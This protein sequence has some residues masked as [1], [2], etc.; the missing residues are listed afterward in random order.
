[1]DRHGHYALFDCILGFIV[2]VVFL[3]TLEAPEMNNF[4]S[5]A[6]AQKTHDL[7]A[8]WQAEKIVSP[9]ELRKDFR[10]AFGEKNGEIIAGEEKIPVGNP[11]GA[12]AFSSETFFLDENLKPVRLRVTVFD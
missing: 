11:H 6:I 3:S 9:E 10:L 8:V 2:I 7:L 5:L 12:K 4:T 1:M